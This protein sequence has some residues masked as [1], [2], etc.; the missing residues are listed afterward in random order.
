MTVLWG[1]A[2]FEAAPRTTIFWPGW[3]NALA[4]RWLVLSSEA[5]D[6]RK[7]TAMPPSVSPLRTT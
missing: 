5:S 1:A 3:M 4:E 6:T 7:C 2:A